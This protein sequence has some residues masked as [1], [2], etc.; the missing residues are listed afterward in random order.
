MNLNEQKLSGVNQIH[1]VDSL[2]AS[3]L[4][5]RINLN[6]DS[7]IPD[8]NDL[9]IYV[10]KKE[11]TEPTAERKKY[12]FNLKHPLQFFNDMSDIFSMD[13]IFN[14]NKP[15][16]KT[17]VER[18][19][20]IQSGVKE[21]LNDKEIED[22]DYSSITLFENENYIYTNY[23]NAYIELIYPKSDDLNKIFLNNY[24]YKDEKENNPSYFNLDDIYFKDAFT[25]TGD[26]LNLDVD[27]ININKISSKNNKF[28]LDSE[29]NLIVKS[30]NFV[31]KPTFDINMNEILNN[32]YPI[33]SIYLS[34]SEI[35]PGTLFGGT[36]IP[37]GEGRMLVGFD[38]Y[39]IDFDTSE[40]TGG[41]KTHVLT[42]EEMPSH[43][44]EYVRQPLWYSE[45][46]GTSG[47]L[48][49]K[50]D[51][52]NALFYTSK[53]TGGNMPHN[54]MPPYIVVHMWKRIV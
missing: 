47:A 30:I 13:I 34:T 44:H 40:K 24:I 48:A 15:I 2:N 50:T 14:N 6:S 31:D 3:L 38:S 37:F 42:I 8:S 23:D 18:N 20:D 25:K 19:I 12:V 51:L 4:K 1:I 46:D 26:K 53:N 41:E 17:I 21:L 39:Q 28:S 16:V 9:I 33:N 22:L 35:N 54:N 10:D 27:D 45:L 43:N 7:I 11:K 52:A 32:V 5:L 29:G 49:D 36:W